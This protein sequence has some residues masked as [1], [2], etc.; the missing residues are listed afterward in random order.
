MGRESELS[1]LTEA[2]NNEAVNNKTAQHLVLL[3][4][5]GGIGKSTTCA[6][7]FRSTA[8]QHFDNLAWVSCKDGIANGLA[9]SQIYQTLGIDDDPQKLL[10]AI[11]QLKG[12]TL[13]VLDDIKDPKDALLKSFRHLG[14]PGFRLVTT[15]RLKLPGF[16]EQPIGVLP[17][18]HCLALFQKFCASNCSTQTKDVI[19]QLIEKAGRHTLTIE[20]IAK[21]MATNDMSAQQMLKALE[22]HGFDLSN[23]VPEAADFIKDGEDYTQALN[24]ALR[25]LFDI[26]QLNEEHQFILFLLGHFN[27]AKFVKNKVKDWFLL[28]SLKALNDLEKLGWL[29]KTD[30]INDITFYSLH[31][32][33]SDLARRLF[34]KEIDKEA[35]TKTDTETE[36]ET[37]TEKTTLETKIPEQQLKAYLE[38]ITHSL[39]EENF[40]ERYP[41][42]F[43][44]LQPLQQFYSY[45]KRPSETLA[46]TLALALNETAVLLEKQASYQ[47][48]LPLFQRALEIREQVLGSEHSAVAHSLNNLAAFYNS[49]G[50]YQQALPLY[51]RALAIQEQVLGPVHLDAATSLNN[52]A[53]LYKTTGDY[54]QA[55][56]LYQRALA[57]REQAQEPEHPDV[58]TNLDNLAALYHSKG[59]YQQALP[60][61]QRA[62]AIREHVLRPEHTD[63]ARGL[64][65]LADL[66]RVMGDYQEALP[67]SQR[68]LK[69]NEKALG[70]EHPNVAIS[71]NILAGLYQNMGEYKEALPLY[72]RALAIREQVLGPEHPD[73]ATSLNNLALLYRNMGDYIQALTLYVRCLNIWDKKLGK[74]HPNTQAGAKNFLICVQE[75]LEKQQSGGLEAQ[76]ADFDMQALAPSIALA[77]EILKDELVA[78]TQ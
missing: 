1:A 12:S 34:N 36:T 44:L 76:A 22:S 31:P 41:G 43:H 66:Y 32:V 78:P 62:L 7:W 28:E 73:V 8:T 61:Y 50:N 25:S 47:Q 19:K 4:G 23:T 52:L 55:L 29:S 60:L 35:N 16:K 11:G 71:L 64:N 51:Q 56:P 17:S 69:I 10:H 20:L 74:T 49:M 53:L 59:D 58:A 33:I 3:S 6:K 21:T 70:P 48:A 54:E 40:N 57:I 72:Q 67:L 26:A 27:G 63:V 24:E 37:E 68:A 65:S 42:D 30:T 39:S 77:E 5:I 45:I 2:V 15:S 75:F 18:E 46:L 14:Q 38:Q 9:E 13:L